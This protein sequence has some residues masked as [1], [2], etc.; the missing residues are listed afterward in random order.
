MKK[1]ISLKK[2]VL[3]AA[4]T[5][6]CPNRLSAQGWMAIAHNSQDIWD[7]PFQKVRVRPAEVGS[8]VLPKDFTVTFSEKPNKAKAFKDLEQTCSFNY[9]YYE[10]YKGWLH[11]LG[12]NNETYALQAAC[13]ATRYLANCYEKGIGCVGDLDKALG[14][15]VRNTSDAE[16]MYKMGYYT[17][18]CRWKPI[19]SFGRKYPNTD[20]ARY[21]YRSAAE[22][23]HKQAKVELQKLGN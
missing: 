5:L 17:M 11:L 6:L 3:F 2:V 14:L 18:K 8:F 22:M 16:S 13:K 19:I 12:Y 23:G 10:G 20:V 15:W 21:F 9:Q 4:L 1:L 7:I